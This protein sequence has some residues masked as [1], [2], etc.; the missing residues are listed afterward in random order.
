MLNSTHQKIVLEVLSL[1]TAPFVEG[2][3]VDWL[4][5]FCRGRRGLRLTRD[6]AG[7][8]LVHLRRGRSRIRRPVCLAAH[9]DHPGFIADRM[10][11][12]GRLRAHWRGGVKPEYFV[13]SGVRFHAEDRRTRGRV[14]SISTYRDGKI[15]RVK[16]A[17]LEVSRPVPAGAPGM[18][19]LP[20]PS[21]GKRL[22]RAPACDDLVGAAAM[23]CAVEQILRR[24]MGAEAYLLFTRAEEVGF[25]GALNACRLGTVPTKCPVVVVETSSELPSARIGDGPVMR[26][27]DR[28]SVFHPAS[29]AWCDA[30]ATRLAKRDRKFTYQRKLMDGGTCEASAFNQFGYDATCVCLALGNYHNMDVK[31]KRLAPEYVSLSD[32]TSL[33]KLFVELARS[34]E[35]YTGKQ[36]DLRQRLARIDRQYRR[37]IDQTRDTPVY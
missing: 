27:G 3:V 4:E 33:V 21:I 30:A 35:P 22:I 34:T 2:A 5:R 14:R 26:V 7:N 1:P 23:V 15:T 20:A 31:R 8:V 25:A 18:W 16:S 37:L 19:A 10:T 29:S 11:A 36:A 6:R 17:V 24:R 13:G 12:P 28:A 9:L 32:F